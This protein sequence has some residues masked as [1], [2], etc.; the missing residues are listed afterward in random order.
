M[1]TIKVKFEGTTALMLNNP[2]CINPMHPLAKAL[3]AITS[4]RNK[5]DE[6]HME[7]IH[8]QFLAS[9][10]LNKKGQYIIPSQMIAKSIEAGA[11]ENKLG[12]KFQRSVLVLGDALLNFK[13]NGCSPEELYQNHNETYVDVR[14]VGIMKAKVIAARMIIPEWSLEFELSYD[15]TQLNK[16][17]IWN[18]INAAG[19]RYGIGT[20]RACFGRYKASEIK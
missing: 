13:D 17:E 6:D 1:K 18:A 5:T 8:L 11:K 19:L 3:K 4:K 9:P 12:A 15:E 16:S 7:I 14:A 2:Q 10:Y 20:Y